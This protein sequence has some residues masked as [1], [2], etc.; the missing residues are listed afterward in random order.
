MEDDEA[1]PFDDFIAFLVILGVD[2]EDAIVAGYEILKNSF[3]QREK[4]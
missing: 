1:E 4:G 2:F 3:Y